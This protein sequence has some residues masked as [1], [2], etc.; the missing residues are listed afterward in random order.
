VL[1][2]RKSSDR[3]LICAAV[4]LDALGAV[5]RDRRKRIVAA[6]V[7]RMQASSTSL[8]LLGRGPV[9]GTAR[10]D[11]LA[12]IFSG[13]APHASRVTMTLGVI[14]MPRA[15]WRSS[16]FP[17]WRV[18]EKPAGVDDDESAPWAPRQA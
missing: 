2:A 16:R 1:P 9:I 10:S 11:Y 14:G 4:R 18:E 5:T 8:V 7:Q 13:S 6:A 17:S 15:R 3:R 12:V